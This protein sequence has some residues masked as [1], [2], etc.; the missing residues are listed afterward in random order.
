MTA[1][2]LLTKEDV[3]AAVLEALDEHSA[4]QTAPTE[5]QYLHGLKE[6]AEFCNLGMTTAWRISKVIPSYRTGRKLFFKKSDVLNALK[7]QV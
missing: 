2:S 7:Q 3:K 6:L 5:E 4:V 1:I